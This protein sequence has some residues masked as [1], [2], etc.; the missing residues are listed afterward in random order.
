[1]R[2]HGVQVAAHGLVER[3]R[4][5][6][7]RTHTC[8]GQVEAGRTEHAVFTREVQRYSNNVLYV[9]LDIVDE[10]LEVVSDHGAHARRVW[11]VGVRRDAQKDKNRSRDD[12]S[13]TPVAP[14]FPSLPLR[15]P[16]RHQAYARECPKRR[17]HTVSVA[18]KCRYMKA[19]EFA[20]LLAS[21]RHDRLEVVALQS[22]GRIDTPPR[23]WMARAEPRG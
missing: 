15:P 14:H 6:P 12:E 13:H 3:E 18:A 11:R 7:D 8:Q 17:L 1:T 22:G 9:Q 21:L 4:A 10:V 5:T 23:N 16:S 19:N 20:K 2:R